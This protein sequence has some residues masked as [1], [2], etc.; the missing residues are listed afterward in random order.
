VITN[1][2]I[3]IFNSG[4]DPVNLGGWSVQYG[5]S[6]G[7]TWSVT[8]LS[9]VVQPGRYHLVQEGGGTSGTT[10]LPAPDST[11]TI[12]MAA[13]DGKVAL[14]RSVTPLAGEC[15]A[16]GGD[17]VDLVGYGAANCSEGGAPAPA[18]AANISAVRAHAGCIDTDVNGS[19]FGTASPPTPRNSASPLNDCTPPATVWPH[20]IQGSG[21][22]SPLVGQLVA[23]RGIVTAKR[24]NNGFFIQTPDADAA[25]EGDAMTS[26][27]IFVFTSIAPSA[28]NIGDEVT[29]TGTVAEFSPSADPRQPP[30]TEI[31]TPTTTLHATGHP[32]PAPVALTGVDLGPTGGPLQL[33]KYEGMRVSTGVLTVVAPTAGNVNETNAT[34]SNNGV[35]YAVFAGIAPGNQV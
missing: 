6:G 27:G 12:G 20:V 13:G 7:S 15:P 1:D 19:D 14:V 25:T 28:V 33:E 32:L 16:A 31:V 17:L 35:F 11:G 30:V 22:V 24:F 9:G 10:P 26:E 4:P 18:L 2:F 34:G 23:V 8:A 21:N 29:V 5:S 3:E